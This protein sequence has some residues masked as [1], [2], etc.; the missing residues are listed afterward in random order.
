MGR[1]QI[2]TVSDFSR[3]NIRLQCLEQANNMLQKLIM[4]NKAWN[5]STKCIDQKNLSDHK[6]KRIR[7]YD[8]THVNIRSYITDS[9][10]AETEL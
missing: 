3:N 6:P 4:A 5:E 1:L 10:M 7:K 9:N 8:G 2:I